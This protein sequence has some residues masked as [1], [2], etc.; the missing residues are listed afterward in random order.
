MPVTQEGLSKLKYIKKKRFGEILVLV[1]VLG[2]C[3]GCA[4]EEMMISSVRLV[5]QSVSC[6]CCREGRTMM[7]PWVCGLEDMRESEREGG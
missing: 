5:S 4:V 7:K 3:F 1:C 6:L 2:G